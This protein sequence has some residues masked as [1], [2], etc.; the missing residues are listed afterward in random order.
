MPEQL[1]PPNINSNFFDGYYKEI[2]RHMFPE[3]TTQAETDFIIEECQ[4]KPGDTVLDLMCGYGRHSLLLGS[5]EIHVTAV[6]NLPDYINEIN[7]IADKESLPVSGICTDVVDMDLHEQFDAVICM[8]NSIQFFNNKEIL[9]LF[10][11]IALHLK[12]G[13]K[14]IINSCSLGEI[15]IKLFKEKTWARIDDMILITENKYLFQPTRIET[16][17]I[18]IKDNGEREEKNAVDYIYSISEFEDMLKQ[19]GFRLEKIYSI[20]GK[21]IFSLGEPRAYIVSERIKE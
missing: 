11:K 19:S 7:K 8:G 12:P 14:M 4:L 6:D 18:I 17:S 3:K 1:K 15:A 5:K 10:R 16:T 20:P 9:G 13:N 2:W 21:K